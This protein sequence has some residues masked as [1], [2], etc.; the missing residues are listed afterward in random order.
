MEAFE[1]D[2]ELDISSL[3]KYI[4][5]SSYMIK[6]KQSVDFASLLRS[7]VLTCSLL[8]LCITLYIRAYSTPLI[9]KDVSFP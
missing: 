3:V 5:Y 9:I 2:L 1:D 8:L 6:I 4:F 7:S